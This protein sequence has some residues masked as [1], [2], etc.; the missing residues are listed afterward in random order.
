[1]SLDYQ[2]IA[3]KY[4]ISASAVQHLAR[5]IAIGHGN[6]AQFNHPE[7]GGMGQWMPSMMMI[8][9]IFNYQLKAKVDAICHELAQAYQD[10]DLETRPTMKP[11]Q[12]TQW[13]SSGKYK[14]PSL[15]G[16]QNNWRYA[17]FA[18]KHRLILQ[19]NTQETMYNTSPHHLTG[20]SQQQSK[21]GQHLI[22]HTTAGKT[23]TLEDFEQVEQ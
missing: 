23:L 20:V 6:Q 1:V 14:N 4:E 21:M 12:T 10:G 16:G 17:Y 11:M 15:V 5:A 9:D 18:D 22:F 3:E 13:W 2:N 8:G 19:K 7:L